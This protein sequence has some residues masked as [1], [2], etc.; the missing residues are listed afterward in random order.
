MSKVQAG[1]FTFD[2]DEDIVVF[3]VGMRIN[4]LRKVHRWLPVAVAMPRM[5]KELFRDTGS[6]LLGARTFVSGRD[7]MVVQYWRD[8]EHLERYARAGDS[9]HLPAWRAFN[10]RVGTSGD[11][12]VW[13]ETYCIAPGSAEAI[14]ANMPLHGLARA[15]TAVPV[16]RRGESAAYRAGRSSTDAP[17]VPVPS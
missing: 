3:L 14:Y 8:F 17:V 10:R 13:H 6:G 11:V 16:A 4:K 5:L 7:V 2:H 15:T 12:G 1:R 9:A